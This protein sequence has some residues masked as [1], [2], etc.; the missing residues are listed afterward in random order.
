MT[1]F[2]HLC[3]YYGRTDQSWQE[4]KWE[5]VIGVVSGKVF[6]SGFELGTPVAQRRY[7]SALCPWGYRRQR[8]WQFFLGWAIPL[9]LVLLFF[10]KNETERFIEVKQ[11]MIFC[12]CVQAVAQ[13]NA[14]SPHDHRLWAH[15]WASYLPRFSVGLQLGMFLKYLY[16]L[17]S[18]F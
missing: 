13:I 1:F 3:L 12:L 10:L 7:M 4:A 2:G 18:L 15:I 17:T 11:S 5:R 9:M 6:E 14:R 16:F 8:W